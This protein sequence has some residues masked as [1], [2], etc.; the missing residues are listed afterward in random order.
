MPHGQT[1]QQV[2][3]TPDSGL[4]WSWRQQTLALRERGPPKHRRSRGCMYTRRTRE[5]PRNRTINARL[6][7]C[8]EGRLSALRATRRWTTRRRLHGDTA[9]MRGRADGM[10]DDGVG[11]GWRRR[12]PLY[13]IRNVRGAGVARTVTSV[14]HPRSNDSCA[15]P[16]RRRR[17]RG[18]ATARTGAKGADTARGR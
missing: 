16:T 1:P 17:R 2:D 12:T 18:W 4:E 6:P 15:P 14:R 13:T 3:G 5:G 10:L 11:C 8:H 9:Q 7:T